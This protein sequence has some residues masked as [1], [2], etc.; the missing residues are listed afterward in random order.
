MLGMQIMLAFTKIT[1]IKHAYFGQRSEPPSENVCYRWVKY[2]VNSKNVESL[3]GPSWSHECHE[4]SLVHILTLYGSHIEQIQKGCALRPYDKVWCL[5][6]TLCITRARPH[7]ASVD[8]QTIGV[9][10]SMTWTNDN[11]T[12]GWANN[13]INNPFESF[14]T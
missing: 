7:M 9:V 6:F 2:T 8:L 13:I 12:Y 1:L 3:V 14:Q 5:L 4:G 10:E 11:I